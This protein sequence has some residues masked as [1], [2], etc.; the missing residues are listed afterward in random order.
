MAHALE[1]AFDGETP[2]FSPR[3]PR[4]DFPLILFEKGNKYGIPFNC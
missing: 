1:E 2:G 3:V 4:F